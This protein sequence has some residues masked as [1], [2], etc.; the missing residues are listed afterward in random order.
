M[1]TRRLMDS[2][3]GITLGWVALFASNP[4]SANGVYWSVGV[5]SPVIYQQPVVV[6]PQPQVVYARP[7][8]IYYTQPG[9]VYYGAPQV[10]YQGDQHRRHH[11]WHRGHGYGHQGGVPQVAVR[12]SGHGQ[13]N[14]KGRNHH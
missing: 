7:Q 4:A 3:V 11:G 6:Y 13:S 12:I 1:K 2:A 8:P 5:S 14:E 9:P 10:I